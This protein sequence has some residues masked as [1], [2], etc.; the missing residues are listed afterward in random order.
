MT[1]LH[2]SGSTV[3]GGNEQQLV[4]LIPEQEA[5]GIKNIVLLKKD[6]F[7]EKE[8]KNRNISYIQAKKTKK[9]KFTFYKY[10]R[11]LIQELK[12][13]I[14]HFHTSDFLTVYVIT[15]KLYNLKTPTVYIRKSMINSKSFVG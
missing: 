2:I 14:I 1:V 11:N 5:L 13:D 9:N 12:P 10:F 8:C 3:W 15:D 4:S 7:L 6:S